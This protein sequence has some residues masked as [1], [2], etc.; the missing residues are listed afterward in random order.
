MVREGAAKI[1]G[2]IET[3]ERLEFEP[4]GLQ[5]EIDGVVWICRAHVYLAM[6]K[7]TGCECSR[8]PSHHSS[9]FELLPTPLVTRGVQPVGRLDQDS[10][11][12]LLMSDDGAFNHEVSSPNRHVSKTYLAATR[13]PP[14]P[15]VVARLLSGVRLRGDKEP[16]A[17]MR[18]EVAG[19]H[20]L[21]IEI[22]Q[23]KY[24]QVKRM[25]A[26][27]GAECVG[28]HRTAIGGLLLERLGLEP[29]QWCELG[30][31]ELALLRDR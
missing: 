5:V 29:A 27:A 30:D 10:S 22:D 13:S 31:A 8:N 28:L 26:A 7:P 11:G 2:R 14:T 15:E 16:L 24:H 18:C 21:E 25:L 12:L 4:D 23:G 20:G 9:V 1:A 3:D 6:H 19:T 17:A